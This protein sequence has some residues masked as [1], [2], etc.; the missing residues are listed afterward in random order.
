VFHVT[1]ETGGAPK[2]QE[3]KGKQVFELTVPAGESSPG[4]ESLAINGKRELCGP[5]GLCVHRVSGSTGSAKAA[6][7]MSCLQKPIFQRSHY[8]L[9]FH[10]NQTGS[11]ICKKITEVTL[12]YSFY[13]LLIKREQLLGEVF[14][15]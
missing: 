4:Q 10:R 5:I 14:F 6:L 2:P 9:G 1:I 11:F 8:S 7:K 12:T 3:D 13:C 15:A